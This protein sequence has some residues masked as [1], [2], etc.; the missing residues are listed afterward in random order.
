MGV[1]FLPADAMMMG[2]V[3]Q[4]QDSGSQGEVEVRPLGWRRGAQ[5]G[6]GRKEG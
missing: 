1:R 4:W 3:L 2:M 6:Q 5:W